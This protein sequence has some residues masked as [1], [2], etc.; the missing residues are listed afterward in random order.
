MFAE[1]LRPTLPV[2]VM[3][4]KITGGGSGY[5]WR[6]DR[7]PEPFISSSKTGQRHN[8]ELRRKSEKYATGGNATPRFV[9]VVELD[10]GCNTT[11]IMCYPKVRA[12]N[13]HGPAAVRYKLTPRLLS[14]PP[15]R[16]AH[17]RHLAPGCFH[18]GPV[19]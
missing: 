1:H 4:W 13:S 3:I 19:R 8:R 10:D 5:G 15:Y 14:G 16:W 12:A 2:L 18:A 11:M 7:R 9:E 17:D 6:I